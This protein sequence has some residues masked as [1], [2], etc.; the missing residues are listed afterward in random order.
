MALSQRLLNKVGVVGELSSGIGRL[1]TLLY[2]NEGG[3]VVCSDTTPSARTLVQ[4]E[5]NADLIRKAGGQAVHVKPDVSQAKEI[6]ALIGAAVKR[7][8]RLDMREFS[9]NI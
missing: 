3:K 9:F 4:D 1:I 2:A 8:G 6:E 5:A 7:F